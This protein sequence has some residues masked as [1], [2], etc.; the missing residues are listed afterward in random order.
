MK[1]RVYIVFIFSLLICGCSKYSADIEY[2]LQQAGDNRHELEMVLKHYNNPHDTLKLKAA[3]FLIANMPGHVSFREGT[4]AEFSKEIMPIWESDADIETKKSRIDSLIYKYNL[5]SIQP[6]QDVKII[7]GD[8]LIHNIDF[9]FE[10]WRKPWASHLTFEEFCEYLLPYKYAE[11]QQLDNW[12]DSLYKRESQLLREKMIGG[13]EDNYAYHIA[14]IITDGLRNSIYPYYMPFE[15]SYL[16]YNE[17]LLEKI[18]YGSQRG[19]L[20]RKSISVDF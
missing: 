4:F 2:A 12:K 7:S 1:G 19:A 13:K 14:R 3:E 18:R 16:F 5:A 11:Y 20:F 9:S 6:E 8:Y 17:A 15:Y 10:L